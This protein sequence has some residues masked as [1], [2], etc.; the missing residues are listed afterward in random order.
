MSEQNK[1]DHN[2][3]ADFNETTAAALLK[4]YFQLRDE[5]MKK[6]GAFFLQSNQNPAQ[7]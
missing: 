1:N 6:Y 7:E 2:T 4:K 3:P 5:F